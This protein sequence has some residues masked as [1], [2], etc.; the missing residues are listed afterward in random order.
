GLEQMHLSRLDVVVARALAAAGF[1]VLRF[2]GQGY[3]DSEGT[4]EHIGLAS[5]LADATDAIRLLSGQPGVERVGVLGAR[6]GG[7]VAA[8]AAE[9]EGLGLM[10]LWEPMERG[11]QCLRDFLRARGFAELVGQVE[12]SGAAPRRPR[13]DRHPVRPQPADRDRDGR[14]GTRRPQGRAAGGE[15]LVKEFP[16][17][18]PDGADHFGAV[19]TV[20]DSEPKGLV[21]LL[22]GTGA[23]RS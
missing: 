21:L 7:T 19:I 2:H 9:R 14:M 1:P 10:G 4:D 3:G 16:V 11:S 23:A 8:L 6:F 13:E 20:P 22:T 5:H 12:E 15:R 18:V 17:F